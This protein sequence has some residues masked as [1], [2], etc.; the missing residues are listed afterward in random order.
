MYELTSSLLE[1][2]SLALALALTP[3]DSTHDPTAVLARYQR[4]I[5]PLE[6]RRSSARTTRRSDAIAAHFPRLAPLAGSTLGQRRRVRHCGDLGAGEWDGGAWLL[7]REGSRGLSIGRHRNGVGGSTGR[8][9]MQ[10]TRMVSGQGERVD[11]GRARKCFICQH[12]RLSE[13]RG[14]ALRDD[15]GDSFG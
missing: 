14:S 15:R 8:A 7:C 6:A 11:E 2:R 9:R 13:L 1:R 4:R 12:C 3:L 10:S 5:P